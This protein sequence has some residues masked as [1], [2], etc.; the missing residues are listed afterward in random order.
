MSEDSSPSRGF[1]DGLKT[2]PSNTGAVSVLSVIEG[3]QNALV[4]ASVIE[5]GALRPT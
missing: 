5:M 1:G 2:V 3:E 4:N